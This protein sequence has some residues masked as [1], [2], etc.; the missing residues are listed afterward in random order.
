MFT[1]EAGRPVSIHVLRRVL[2]DLGRRAGIDGDVHPHRLRH[3]AATL[4]LAA[5]SR[6]DL[7][8]ADVAAMLGH[9]HA[10]VTLIVYDHETTEGMRS[11]AK[12]L[13]QIVVRAATR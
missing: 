10:T 4:L 13:D 8:L 6:G 3:A 2:A 5:E 9:A 7:T 12:A 11:A 1:D